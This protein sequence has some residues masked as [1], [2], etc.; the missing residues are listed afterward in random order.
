MTSSIY[1][2][3][4]IVEA[5]WNSR[6]LI[7]HNFIN[8]TL[9]RQDDGVLW[10]AVREG[11]VGNYINIYKSSD[12]GFSWKRMWQ[13][14]FGSTD[15]RTGI[16][17]LNA[18]GPV[19]H[20]TLQEDLGLLHLFHSYYDTNEDQYNIELFSFAITSTTT[21]LTRLDPTSQTWLES[22]F[23]TAMDSLSFDI[24]YTDDMIYMVYPYFSK[25][26]VRPYRHTYFDAADGGI[27][28]TNEEDYYDIFSTHADDKSVLHIAALRD[29]S[30]NI[31]VS[32]LKFDRLNGSFTSPVQV[33]SVSARDIVDINISKDGLGTLLIYWSQKSIDDLFVNEY[34]SLSTDNGGTWSEP[35]SIPTTASQ[36]DFVDIPTNQ[37]TGRTVS[38]G[39][40][41]GFLLSYVRNYNNKAITYVRTVDYIDNEY[42][43]SS[44]SI[45]ASHPTKDVV[46]L[47]FFKPVGD[48]RLDLNTKE[49]IRF[50]YQ[51][52][53]GDSNVQ[54]DKAP[55]FFGQKL[56]NDEAFPAINII[57]Y[58]E[59]EAM[60]NQL[61]FSFNLL[62]STSENIDYYTEGLVGPLTNKYTSAFNRFGTSVYIEQYEPI[63]SSVLSDKSSYKLDFAYFTKA[64]FQDIN[65]GFPSPS[66]NESFE[67]YIERDMRKLHLPPDFHLSRQF[68]INDGNKLKRT[69]WILVFGGNQYEI[70]QVVPKFVDNQIVYYTA[71]AYVVGPSRNPFSRTILPSET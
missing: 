30:P 67:S 36:S 65:Y 40:S 28:G 11:H 47:R 26:Y 12:N 1:T 10:A 24:S 19:M 58:T 42:L 33:S 18:N 48:G 14:T 16:T 50:A 22:T 7:T 62:G 29:T 71:N 37:K 70:S 63:Q 3:T 17:G 21:N 13:G 57:E 68:I 27:N 35:I 9:I 34:Y 56:L 8:K 61:L 51:I 52:G 38:I 4:G 53:L 2:N 31:D 59:D 15:R 23:E 60:E 66:A 45:A 25:L 6:G 39:C 5:S 44:E 64:F 32:Y 54:V 43:L 20:L 69:V 55:V 49:E 46:G 41:S